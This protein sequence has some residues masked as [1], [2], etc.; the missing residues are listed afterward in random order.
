M[1]T[2]SLAAYLSR[3]EAGRRGVVSPETRVGTGM[4]RGSLGSKARRSAGFER[5]PHPDPP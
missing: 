4:K 2:H 1:H 5:R 3:L